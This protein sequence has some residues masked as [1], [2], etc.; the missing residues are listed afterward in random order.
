M[1]YKPERNLKGPNRWACDSLFQSS[2]TVNLCLWIF[3]SEL[4]SDTVNWGSCFAKK[5]KR[6]CKL[7][8]GY[9]T[10]LIEHKIPQL[11]YSENYCKE[12]MFDM[13]RIISLLK[14]ES[15]FLLLNSFLCSLYCK[16]LGNSTIIQQISLY[17][18]NIILKLSQITA[19]AYFLINWDFC[20]HTLKT[21]RLFRISLLDCLCH[22]FYKQCLLEMKTRTLTK[23]V[24][25]IKVQLELLKSYTYLEE[26]Y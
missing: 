1:N 26:Y 4:N 16:L 22:W 24:K 3:C 14:S 9:V 25:S 23:D 21:N 10:E 15:P 19:K 8:Q 2:G 7:L 6:E 17:E 11:K 13:K 20:V 5:S 12:K 18:N